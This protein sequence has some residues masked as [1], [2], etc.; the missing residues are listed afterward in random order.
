MGQQQDYYI[1]EEDD[2]LEPVRRGERAGARASGGLRSA[3]RGAA[4]TVVGGR[5]RSR[6]PVASTLSLFVCG[7]GQA[8]NGQVKLGLLLFLA[9]ALAV[10]GHWSVV[11]IW[12]TLKDLGH[13][14][15]IS[16][17]EIFLAV[18]AG[19]FLLIFFL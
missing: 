9:E 15:A 5:G 3:D 2:L 14:F 19:D 13:I 11:R 6:A 18:A 17:Q 16:E 4:R 7:A 12:P 8:Y 10:V 1:I